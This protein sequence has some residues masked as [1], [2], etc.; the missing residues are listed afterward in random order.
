LQLDLVLLVLLAA[1]MHAS[2]NT[3][4]KISNDRLANLATLTS[5]G[6]ALV[7]LA[8]PFSGLPAPESLPFLAVGTAIHLVYFYFLAG[9]YRLGDFSQVYPLARGAAPAL[10][11]VGAALFADE[12]LETREIAG[13]GLVVLGIASLLWGRPARDPRA[14][15]FA[16]ATG[17]AI[18]CYT[19]VD[20]LGARRAGNAVAFL[21]FLSLGEALGILL[22]ARLRRGPGLWAA[23]AGEGR[24]TVLGGMVATLGYGIIVYAMSRGAMA[25]VSALRETSVIMA[26][27]IGTRLLGEDGL[28]QRLLAAALVVAG[29]VVMNWRG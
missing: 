13:L 27:L 20:G 26:A 10:V 22:F 4:V 25:H 5:S 21:V 28:W 9:A 24:R 14:L 11:A 6:A 23:M 8:L 29:L 1:V 15:L 17:G 16:L 3:L 7:M 19:V 12:W 2:W 18:A